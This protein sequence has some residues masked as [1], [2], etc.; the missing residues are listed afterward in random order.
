MCTAGKFN[1]LVLLRTCGM[2]ASTSSADRHV[3][4]I[5]QLQ[6]L[7]QQASC[8]PQCGNNVPVKALRLCT[9]IQYLAV[10]GPHAADI[11]R[12]SSQQ[13]DETEHQTDGCKRQKLKPTSCR[14]CHHGC[15]AFGV[16]ACSVCSCDGGKGGIGARPTHW[17]KLH[18]LGDGCY[19]GF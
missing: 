17:S 16:A 14:R 6:W 12:C 5:L 10:H 1:D 9:V 8:A 2:P 11:N 7:R 19:S 18:Q 4:V 15:T 3:L 13:G